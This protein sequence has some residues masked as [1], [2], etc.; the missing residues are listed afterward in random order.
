MS[1]D[2]GS[3]PTS[4]KR[5]LSL[6]KFS[7]FSLTE[8][9]HPGS[10]RATSPDFG[11]TPSLYETGEEIRRNLSFKTLADMDADAWRKRL[12]KENKPSGRRPKD[13]DQAIAWAVSPRSS[14]L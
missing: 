13:L 12:F 9:S 8:L 1:E 7:K 6:P 4:P 10:P 2:D 5:S 14:M 3:L 11:Q